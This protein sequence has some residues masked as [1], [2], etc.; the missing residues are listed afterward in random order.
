MNL[1]SKKILVLA[2][3]MPLAGLAGMTRSKISL[4]RTMYKKLSSFS[5]KGFILWLF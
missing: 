5:V 4:L 1:V 3:P 2:L